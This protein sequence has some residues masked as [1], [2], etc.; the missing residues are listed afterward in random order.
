MIPIKIRILNVKIT[1]EL[2][3]NFIINYF[4]KKAK[5]KTKRKLL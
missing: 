1:E 3:N 4:N 5:K 2:L